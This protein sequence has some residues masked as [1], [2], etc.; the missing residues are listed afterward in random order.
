MYGDHVVIKLPRITKLG[1]P[2]KG[3]YVFV[4]YTHPDHLNAEIVDPT[5]VKIVKFH[6]KTFYEAKGFIESTRNLAKVK[7]D[8]N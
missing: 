5:K 2:A 3:P 4:R 7:I 8:S 6:D 1:F